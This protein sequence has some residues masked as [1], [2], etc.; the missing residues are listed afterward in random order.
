MRYADVKLSR[1]SM[2]FLGS[3]QNL[4]QSFSINGVTFKIN[5]WKSRQT[6]LIYKITFCTD[7]FSQDKKH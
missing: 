1:K 7:A 4:K 2:R 5:F 6:I 3:A